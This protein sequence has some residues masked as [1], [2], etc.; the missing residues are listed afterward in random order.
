MVHTKEPKYQYIKLFP[1]IAE[2]L[3]LKK[4]AFSFDEKSLNLIPSEYFSFSKRLI[5]SFDFFSLS[6]NSM[7]LF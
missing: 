4:S 7:Y 6:S 5:Y 1:D 2:L 3:F